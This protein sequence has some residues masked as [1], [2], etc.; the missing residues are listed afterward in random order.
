MDNCLNHKSRDMYLALM[1]ALKDPNLT[2]F[3]EGT[4][5]RLDIDFSIVDDNN[6]DNDDVKTSLV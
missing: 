1:I 2:N 3:G 4:C 5:S 6:D